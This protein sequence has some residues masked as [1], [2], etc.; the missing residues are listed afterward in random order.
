MDLR[1]GSVVQFVAAALVLLPFALLTET[2]A[3]T[4]SA[5]LVFAL[6]WSVLVMSLAAI[7]LLYILIRRGAA[8]NVSSL[9]YLVPPTTAI[10]A[11]LFF[12]EALTPLALLGLVATVVGVALVV[13]K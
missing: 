8:T 1:T 6:A 5:R 11:Y 12:D 10:M 3:V 7:T 2:F 4:W 13:R 9:F